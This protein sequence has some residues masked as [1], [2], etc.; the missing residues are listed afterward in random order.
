MDKLQELRDYIDELH[1]K[2]DYEDYVNLMDLVYDIEDELG[3]SREANKRLMN[4]KRFLE[5]SIEK[6]QSENKKLNEYNEKLIWDNN[7]LM[8]LSEEQV[9]E[10]TK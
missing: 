3:T 7:Q 2:I 4:T 8:M 6:L 1:I 9:N 5:D 10:R